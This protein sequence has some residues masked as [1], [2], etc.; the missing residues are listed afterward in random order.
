[1]GAKPSSKPG[2]AIWGKMGTHAVQNVGQ[3]HGKCQG[4]L[5]G[6]V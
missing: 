1:M 3:G 5:Q 6:P 4:A 2:F